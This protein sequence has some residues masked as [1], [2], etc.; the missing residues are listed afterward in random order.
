[1]AR[2]VLLIGLWALGPLVWLAGLGADAPAAAQ[3]EERVWLQIEARSTAIEAELAAR[4]WAR[5]FPDVVAFSLPSG[6]YAVALG[7]QGRAAAENRLRRL[8]AARVVPSDSFIA[9]AADLG[10]PF[11]GNTAAIGS[12]TGIEITR[13]APPGARAAQPAAPGA[14]AEAAPELAPEVMPEAAPE[15]PT[16]ETAAPTVPTAPGPRDVQ[17]ALAWF[18][19]YDGAID[20]VI[21]PASR[22]AIAAYQRRI[23]TPGTGQ[24]SPE[25]ATALLATYRG[26]TAAFGLETRSYARAGLTATLPLALVEFA[27]YAPPFV[28][29]SPLGG[30][31]VALAL[32]SQRGGRETLETLHRTLPGLEGM[33]P[34]TTGLLEADRFTL[35]GQAGGRLG[36]AE[37][38]LADGA[39]KGFVISWPA[40]RDAGEMRRLVATIRAGLAPEPGRALDIAD[41]AL[42]PEARAAMTGGLA[43]RVARFTRSGVFVD[44]G[45]HVLTA[46]EGLAGCARITIGTDEAPMRLAAESPATG[47]ALLSPQR[48]LAP[49]GSAS[50]R[51]SPPLIGAE[52][53]VAGYPFG[54]ALGAPALTIGALA[55]TAGLGGETDRFRLSLPALEGDIGGPV[56]D[57]TGA[58]AGLLLPPPGG[59]ARRL[60][61][62]VQHAATARAIADFLTASGLGLPPAPR[63]AARDGTARARLAAQITVPVA[64]WES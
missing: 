25:E 11:W 49:A 3:T 7:P 41:I 54:L 53:V 46:A 40:T 52:L 45:G 17:R 61:E 24:L 64:C 22:T 19:L 38:L 2:V 8:R 47:L 48:P 20:G 6:W 34:G 16:P 62:G 36:H 59:Q 31:D 26:E 4:D 39:V 13:L 18:E 14:E 42:S 9:T 30:S 58:L 23:G 32:I 27:G 35:T 63:G 55:D 28:R 60:P 33:P 29:F 21:G 5:D 12:G 15:A 57:A 10:A 51:L 56:L 44:G 37:A 1:M 43:P 50:L